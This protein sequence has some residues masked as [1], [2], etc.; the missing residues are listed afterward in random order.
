[1]HFYESN[2]ISRE[3]SC[4][5]N[6]YK[7]YRTI[8]EW[9]EIPSQ[10]L[11]KLTNTILEEDQDNLD[12]SQYKSTNIKPQNYN[13]RF[14]HL[15]KEIQ[16]IILQ[17]ASSTIRVESKENGYKCYDSHD[18]CVGKICGNPNSMYWQPDIG[19]NNQNNSKEIDVSNFLRYIG[20]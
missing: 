16:S 8:G 14:A 10:L 5:H 6:R 2:Q 18:R 17:N 19:Q 13:N 11:S 4:L 9:F 12:I 20:T 15:P 1:M 7:Q 3:E